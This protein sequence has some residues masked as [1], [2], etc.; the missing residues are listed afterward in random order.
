[1]PMEFNRDFDAFLSSKHGSPGEDVTYTPAG[2]SASTITVILN[3]EYVDIDTG[4]VPIQ[5]Y[6]PTAHVKTTDIPNIAIND[7]IT[8]P[9]LKTLDGTVYKDATNYKVVNYEN[10]NTGFTS[11]L[12]EVQ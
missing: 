12:L 11:L 4:S 6:K 3:Q 7:T 5:G 10:D 2:G 8:A 9:S 1:M